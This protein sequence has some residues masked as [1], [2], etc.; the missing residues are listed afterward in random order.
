MQM[1]QPSGCRQGMGCGWRVI[2]LQMCPSPAAREAESQSGRARGVLWLLSGRPG[3][4]LVVVLDPVRHG[5]DPGQDPTPKGGW[6][7][8]PPPLQTPKWLYR[9]M[10][11]VGARG[12]GDFVLGIWQGEIFLFDP[13]CLYFDPDRPPG[14]TLADGSLS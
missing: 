2:H 12:A 14:R 7:Y 10:G 13:M 1:A 8:P 11:F 3:K 4:H 9:T 5:A 6:G